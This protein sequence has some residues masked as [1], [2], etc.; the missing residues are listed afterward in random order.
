MKYLYEIMLGISIVLLGIIT[1]Q[2]FQI[3]MFAWEDIK[4]TV[5]STVTA[6]CLVL[7]F[8]SECYKKRRERAQN[9]SEE[10]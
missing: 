5:I 6:S 2:W 9:Q 1:Y 10:C 3:E 8:G 4:S 7:V